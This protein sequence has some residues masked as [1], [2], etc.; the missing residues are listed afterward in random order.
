MSAIV[1]L[2]PKQVVEAVNADPVIPRRGLIPISVFVATSVLCL[3]AYREISS[4]RIQIETAKLYPSGAAAFIEQQGYA[5]PLYN[6]FNWGG[7]FIWRL[8]HLK[9]SMDGRANVHGDER[10]KES[11]GTWTGGPHWNEDADLRNAGVIITKQDM[12]LASLL[13][14]DKSFAEVYRDEI[15]VVFVPAIHET[16]QPKL[17]QQSTQFASVK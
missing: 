17:P 4:E 3:L 5:G 15:A 10:I 11:I 8:P 13:R 12:A 16:T 7:Y 1:I 2:A 9:V 6:H 14:L